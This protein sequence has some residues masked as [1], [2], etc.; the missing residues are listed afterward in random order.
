MTITTMLVI[1][2][3]R[4]CTMEYSPVSAEVQVQCF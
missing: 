2:E 3:P 1:D 4:I